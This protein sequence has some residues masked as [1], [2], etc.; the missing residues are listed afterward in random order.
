MITLL[1]HITNNSSVPAHVFGFLS[2]GDLLT[3]FYSILEKFN[4]N[5]YKTILL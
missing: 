4:F 3:N 1:A 2:C 5:S